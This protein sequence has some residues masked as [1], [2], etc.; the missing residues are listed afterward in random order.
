MRDID[1]LFKAGN[2]AQR[3]KL[4]ENGHKNDFDDLDTFESYYLMM[5]ETKELQL[6]I[7][8]REIDYKAIRHE[9]ADI[10]NFAH[11]IIMAADKVITRIKKEN[12]EI[13]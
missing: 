1:A 3:E 7:Y 5:K 12:N 8:R 10:A 6:E 4:E 9:A 2:Q 13:S 11:M